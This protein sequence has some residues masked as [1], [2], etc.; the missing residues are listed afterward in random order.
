MATPIPRNTAAFVGRGVAFPMAPDATGSVGMAT[1]DRDIEQAI[2]LILGTTPG[3]RPMRPRFGCGIHHHI[4]DAVNPATIGTM[5][6]EVERA[7][8]MWEPRV[9]VR[10]VEILVD[11]TEPSL[12]YIDVTY[13]VKHNNDERNLV[14][15][16]Y[17][18]P[19]E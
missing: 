15:P 6:F 1:E 18:I 5:A 3:E 8:G 9:H 16:F 10:N 13:Q 14:F 4:F 12:L 7:I 11:E 17:T 2:R 19:E